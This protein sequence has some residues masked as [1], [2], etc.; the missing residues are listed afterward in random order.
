MFLHLSVI[1][2]T[3]RS[4]PKCMLEY[5]PLGGHRNPRA[6]IPLGR[7]PRQTPPGEGET[8]PVQTPPS[9]MHAVIH[10]LPSA[11]WDTPPAQCML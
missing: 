8:P 6:D 1:L 7:P 4:L 2:F 9:P 3:G 11:F 5:T 10:P